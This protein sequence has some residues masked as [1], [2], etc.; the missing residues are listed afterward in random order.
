MPYVDSAENVDIEYKKGEM[1]KTFILK[2]VLPYKLVADLNY[3]RLRNVIFLHNWNME[4]EIAGERTFISVIIPFD[5][6]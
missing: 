3:V 2:L 1:E 4:T 6:K 5:L